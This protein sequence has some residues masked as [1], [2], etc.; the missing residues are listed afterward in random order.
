MNLSGTITKTRFQAWA[1]CL[2]FTIVCLSAHASSSSAYGPSEEWVTGALSISLILSL[3]G[4]IGNIFLEERFVGTAMEGCVAIVLLIFWCA[5]LPTIMNP[6]NN[7]AVSIVNEVPD[8]V[9]ANLYFFSWVCFGCVVFLVGHFLQDYFGHD[10]YGNT[11]NKAARWACLAA[12]SMIVLAASAEYY[13]TFD[14][15][16]MGSPSTCFRTKY[17]IGLGAV[18]FLGAAAVIFMVIRDILV[19]TIELGVAALSF[20]LYVFGVA[21][22]TFGAGPGA[23]IS[24]L[25]FAVWISTVLS[26]FFTLQSYKEHQA[27][28]AGGNQE[29][30]AP[31][32]A[33]SA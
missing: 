21:V 22:I 29:S 30:I 6:D 10:V 26:L 1:G 27:G 31:D 2:I 3:V 25:Y 16:R 32:G 4:V 12:S 13:A 24:N 11:S 9:N 23:G 33:T 18:T 17:A 20:V 5:S 7:I 28:Q 14:C 8:V 19:P 15:S